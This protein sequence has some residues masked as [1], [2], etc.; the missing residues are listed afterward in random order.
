MVRIDGE[1]I[2][3]TDISSALAVSDCAVIITDHTSVDYQAVLRD[4][5]LVVDTRNALR[6]ST[7]NKLIRL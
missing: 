3:S 2:F 1:E 6:G 7:S 4:A 5:K